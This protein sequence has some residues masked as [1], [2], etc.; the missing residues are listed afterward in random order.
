M[1][2]SAVQTRLISC[3]ILAIM[4]ACGSSGAGQSG[5]A[6]G[7]SGKTGAG[8]LPTGPAIVIATDRG[9]EQIDDTGAVLRRISPTPARR[10]RLTGDG[11]LVFMARGFAELRR[12]K[13][14]GTGEKPLALIPPTVASSC[15]AA[16]PQPWDPALLLRADVDMQLDKGGQ[17]VCLHFTAGE[18]D[19]ISSAWVRI[20]LPKGGRG[21]GDLGL[22]CGVE[23][24][25]A[26][27]QCKARADSK[28]GK[29]SAGKYEVRADAIV[30]QGTDKPVRKLAGGTLEEVAWAPSSHWSLVVAAVKKGK[31]IHRH[32]LALDRKSGQVYEVAPGQW[33]GPISDKRWQA[34]GRGKEVSRSVALQ[35]DIRALG[36]GGLLVVDTLL[37]VPGE[38]V[39]DTRGQFA[40]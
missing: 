21:R 24:P 27:F 32:V 28:Q 15:D 22:V 6:G 2:T 10:P 30:E 13:L 16:F 34:L 20:D 8:P 4:M 40:L 26:D 17:A 1:S 29:R 25:P 37:I 31:F 14:D 3:S 35:S 33:P 36:H 19:D 39:V 11:H 18:D 9:I 23:P 38:R 7:S 5:G 12:V